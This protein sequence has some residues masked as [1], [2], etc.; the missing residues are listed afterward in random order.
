MLD[1]EM[2][3]VDTINQYLDV[4]VL[5]VVPEDDEI[6]RQSL[7]GGKLIRDSGARMS[8][9]LIANKLHNGKDEIFDVTKKYKGMFG[10]VKRNLKK[11]L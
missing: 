11:I 2:I 8:F 7:S 4:G 1:G 3:S 6:S 9:C 5:G 10:S